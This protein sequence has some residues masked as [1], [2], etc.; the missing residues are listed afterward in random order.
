VASPG[1]SKSRDANYLGSIAFAVNGT[2][3]RSYSTYN[4]LNTQPPYPFQS[5]CLCA[6]P[7]SEEKNPGKVVKKVKR[8]KT[9]DGKKVQ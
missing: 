3:R 6:L 5:L 2:H 9:I 8:D 1:S 7:H 4:L